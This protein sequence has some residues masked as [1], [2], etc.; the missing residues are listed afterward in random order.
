VGAARI[1]VERKEVIPVERDV[2]ADV[3]AATDRV[4][5]ALVMRGMLR[6]KLYTDTHAR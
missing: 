1:T 5:D 6:L 4:T 3:L 2:D